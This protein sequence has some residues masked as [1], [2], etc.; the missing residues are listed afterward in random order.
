[1]YPAFVERDY[2][3]RRL[4]E[5]IRVEPECLGLI[6]NASS[7]AHAHF[8]VDVN[9]IFHPVLQWKGGL[10][11]GNGVNNIADAGDA[12]VGECPD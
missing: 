9:A 7:R 11:S 10:S 3:S 1:M 5:L 4:G 2:L 8:F 6:Q 12:P